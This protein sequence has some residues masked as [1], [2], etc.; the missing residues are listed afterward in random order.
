MFAAAF[1]VL[2]AALVALAIVAELAGEFEP[3]VAGLRIS[4]KST[5]R[6]AA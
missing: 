2:F 4:M 1:D 6:I 5:W 3:G